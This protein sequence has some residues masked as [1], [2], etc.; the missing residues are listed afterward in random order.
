LRVGVDYVKDEAQQR[1]A[2][3]DRLW[4][5]P[6]EYT[7]TAPY[8]QLSYDLGPVTL[9]GG[10]R[11]EDGELHVDSYTTTPYRNSVFVEGG[12]V[13]YTENLVN[14]GAIWRIT[15]QWSV[16]GSYG[17]GFGLP[18]IGIPLRNINEPGQSVDRIRDIQPI[19][20]DNREFGF[21]WRGEK[22]SFGGS[23][24]D[25]RSPFGTSLS[26]DEATNDYV[27]NRAP[28]QIKGIELSGEWRFTD[29]W[30]ASALYSRI[31]GKTAFWNS[32][33]NGDYPAGGL[34]KPIGVSD[35]NPDK[36]GASVTWN[37]VPEAGV[38]L[39]A[40]K[41]L[42]RDLSATDVREFDDREFEFHEHTKGYT[43][44]DLSATYKTEKYGRFT[45]GI[46]N[47]TNK[48]YVLSWS[49]VDF[50]KNYFAGRGRMTSLTY[51][52][53]F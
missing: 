20:V 37:F 18:N 45:V 25:S 42:D 6:M 10:Y 1:L 40:T 24:Y 52:L 51:E 3:T 15:D 23:Y 32:A 31:R 28:T 5:P 13:E 2:L 30:K 14:F 29:T 48:Q 50:Y 4:V 33:L 19:I 12:G 43:L 34:N 53:T 47:L 49:Q 39:S 35:I 46:E 9:S 26:V 16:F 36:I 44:F 17:E 41:L 11:H 27:L 7:S 21:N 38:T 22:G 8:V